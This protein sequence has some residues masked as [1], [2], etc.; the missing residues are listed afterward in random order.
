VPIT[1]RPPLKEKSFPHFTLGKTLANFWA[2]TL[3]ATTFSVGPWEQAFPRILHVQCRVLIWY[4]YR[5]NL[6]CILSCLPLLWRMFIP[7]PE[8][9][10]WTAAQISWLKTLNPKGVTVSCAGQMILHIQ[11]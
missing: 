8:E 1:C 2:Y 5:G 4:S 3:K 10:M 6:T 11:L 7:L 9:C